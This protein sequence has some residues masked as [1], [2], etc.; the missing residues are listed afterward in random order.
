[1][2]QRG[3]PKEQ[4]PGGEGWGADKRQG[5]TPVVFCLRPGG[6]EGARVG[7]SRGQ[8]SLI[9]ICRRDLNPGQEWREAVLWEERSHPTWSRELPGEELD[10][11]T[12][13]CGHYSPSL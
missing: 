6:W 11:T 3:W 7:E 9:Q 10:V 2:D 8:L 5:K 13:L 4:R 1:M 12:R